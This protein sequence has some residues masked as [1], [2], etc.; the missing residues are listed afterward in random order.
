MLALP[1]DDDAAPAPEVEEAP[2]A[3]EAA[4]ALLASGGLG[5]RLLAAARLA[6]AMQALAEAP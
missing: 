5:R 3:G 6:A 4:S 2:S 1:H